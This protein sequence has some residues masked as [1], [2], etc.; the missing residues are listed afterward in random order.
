[1]TYWSLFEGFDEGAWSAWSA[2]SATCGSVKTTF[3]NLCVLANLGTR[4]FF[5]FATTTMGQCNKASKTKK[6]SKTDKVSVSKRSRHIE[7][8][9]NAITNNCLACKH[10]HVVAALLSRAHCPS[11]FFNYFKKSILVFLK[12]QTIKHITLNCETNATKTKTTFLFKLYFKVQIILGA[13][14]EKASLQKHGNLG[15]RYSKK[16]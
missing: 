8:S 7:Y 13:N 11:L 2:C 4:Q 5:S 1:M 3:T 12:R 16:G 14:H 9:N 6:N 10:G 15:G